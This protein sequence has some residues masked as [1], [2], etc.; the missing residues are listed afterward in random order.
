MQKLFTLLLIIS[1]SFLS[2]AQFSIGNNQTICLG[3]TA[4]VIAILS[5]P[6][7]S[8]C[9][10]AID[11][12]VSNIGPSN[13]SNGTMFNIINT[14]GGDMTITGFSQGTY[15]YSGARIMDI[16]YYPGDYV[17]VMSVTAGWTQVATAV[18]INLPIGAT[19]T[20]PLYSPVIPI[21]SVTIPAGATYGFY[22]GGNSTLS[23]ATAPT[24]T[25]PGV[26]PWGSNTLLTITAGHGGNFPSPT[27]FPRGPLIKVYYGGGASW[28]D[29]NTGQMIGSGDTLLYSPSQTTYIAASHSCNGQNYADTM[30]LN[31][32][33][34]QISTTGLSLCN[35]PITLTAASGFALYVWN[36]NAASPQMLVTSAGTYYVNCTNSNGSV[37]Q[38]PPI[39]IYA[40]TISVTVT[41]P[42]TTLVCPGDTVYLQAPLGYSSY[43]W[44]TGITTQSMLAD[45]TGNYWVYSMDANGCVAASDT[46]QIVTNELHPNIW[47][48]YATICNN[49]PVIAFNSVYTDNIYQTYLWGSNSGL[50]STFSNMGANNPGNYWVTVTD[51]SGCSGTSDT[52]TIASGNFTFNLLPAD[53]IFL[54]NAG[55]SVTLDAANSMTV[56][57]YLWNTGATTPTITT[58]VPGNYYCIVTTLS[59]CSGV[60]DTVIVAG[61]NPQLTY[62]GLSLCAGPISL[63]TGN[64]DIYQWSNNT[65]TQAINVNTAGDYYVFVTDS[66]GCTA[67]SDTVSIYTNAF[68]YSIVPSGFTTIC[69]GYS[70]DLDAGNQFTNHLWNTG[71][72]TSTIT[73]STIGQY[74]ASMTD[75]NGCSGYTDTV[76]VTNLSVTLSTTG[77]SLCI[78]NVT[79]NAGGGHYIYN[80]NTGDTVSTITTGL[81]GPY[82]VTVIDENGCSA[83]SDT[84]SIYLN[85]FTFNVNAVGSNF[86]CQ[87]SGQVTLDAGSGFLSYNWSSGGNSQQT[88]VNTTGNYTVS[89]TD[90]NGCPGVSNPFTVHNVVLTSAITGLSNVMQNNVENY[91]VIQNLTSTYN[92][93]V[94]AGILQTGLGTNSVDVLWNTPG[95]GSIY[96]IE[97]DV[98]GCI[99]DTITLA[100]TIFSSTSIKE[101]QTTEISIYPN[102]FTKSTIINLPNIQSNYNLTLYDVTGQKVLEKEDLNQ[103]SYELERGTLTKGIYFLE[104]KTEESKR[105]KRVVVN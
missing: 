12:L 25:I 23:Y 68:Q 60:S 66:N 4:E 31:V 64:Y 30:R 81:P 98:N 85:T 53:S 1:Y 38:S 72:S 42:D 79:L 13:G 62:S 46:A 29:V 49:G 57:S 54:C 102:P 40:D 89:V 76:D 21:T 83:S 28:H 61:I 84:I 7:T 36:N 91:S 67:Y 80:W 33:N 77:Y 34:T 47:S 37:C 58:N 101:S 50:T 75:V 32:L 104:I 59:G 96:V 43:L 94:A 24:G 8:G 78:G 39:T 97:T 95:Q 71:A 5:G 9:N 17:P 14:S 6:G 69:S 73:A 93:S 11:S 99:G 27:N 35:G 18:N 19:T 105:I 63:S 51:Q 16:W 22:I 56:S 103:T 70:V 41:P 74:Y 65:S 3:D 20:T 52:I 15:T 87:P 10:G 48:T 2:F 44:N 82:F 90:M 88:T 100:V 45:S 26:S 55:S 86:L 92:W